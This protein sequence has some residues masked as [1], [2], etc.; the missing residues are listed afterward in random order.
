MKLAALPVLE[1]QYEKEIYLICKL[2]DKH[3]GVGFTKMEKFVL[4][5]YLDIRH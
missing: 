3:K 4:Q 5:M 1:T 2:E